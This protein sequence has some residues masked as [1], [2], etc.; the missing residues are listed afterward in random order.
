MRAK[1][2]VHTPSGRLLLRLPA[3]LHRVV[4]AS[5]DRAGVSVNEYCVR[6]LSAPGPGLALAGPWLDVLIRADE[7]F[8]GRMAGAIAHGSWARGTAGPD[9]DLDVAIVLD[10]DVP[11]VRSMYRQWDTKPLSWEGRHVDVHFVHLPT[12][13]VPVSAFW[14]ELSIDGIVLS[15]RADAVSSHLRSARHAIASGRVIRKLVQGQ[16]YWTDAA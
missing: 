9:S 4:Q 2:R 16:P 3:S 12:S 10:S 13:G 11:L 7:L 15:E 14:Y 5:A 6:T 8:H 1:Q